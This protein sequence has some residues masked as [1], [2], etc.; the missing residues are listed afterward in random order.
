MTV[1]AI[2]FD[3][4]LTRDSGDPYKT[5]GE[6]PDEEMVEFVRSLKED[7]QYDIII[8]TAR[9]WK[10]AAHI[11]G[12]LTMWEV[13]YNGLKMEKGGADCYVDDRAVNHNHPEWQDRVFGLTHHDDQPDPD[14]PVVDDDDATDPATGRDRMDA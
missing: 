2:D 13:P 8:W 6:T 10:H 14:H 3:K 7:H 11:A 4:T 9:P 1:I 12:L 5:G